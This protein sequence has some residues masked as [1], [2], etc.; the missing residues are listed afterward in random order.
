MGYLPAAV[1][2]F[3]NKT[4]NYFQL[5]KFMDSNWISFVHDL[6]PN[7][8]RETYAWNGT[9]ELWPKYDVSNPLDF[10]FDANVSS[11]A[12]A[13]TYRAAGID[14]INAHNYDIYQR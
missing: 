13:D 7:S 14:L 10:V 5:A 2:P 4:A 6:D 12:E 8:W 11:Y 3:T 1:P 9:E